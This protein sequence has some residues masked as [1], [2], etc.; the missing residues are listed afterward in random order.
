MKTLHHK[1]PILS[2]V[3]SSIS[4]V[5]MALLMSVAL[6]SCE[7]DDDLPGGGTSTSSSQFVGTWT[8][9]IQWAYTDGTRDDTFVFRSG[10][11][12]TL[13]RWD[14]LDQKYV[15]RSLSW[16]SYGDYIEISL[17]ETQ[18]YG[19]STIDGYISSGGSAMKIGGDWYNKLM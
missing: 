7:I 13:T 2:E 4:F 8:R 5:L 19:A 3:K 10:G 18:D 15:T 16:Q 17:K 6:T 14:W 1:F 11:T 12:G 9:Q